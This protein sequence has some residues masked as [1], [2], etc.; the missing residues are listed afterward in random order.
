MKE[1]TKFG[2]SSEDTLGI[3]DLKTHFAGFKGSGIKTEKDNLLTKIRNKKTDRLSEVQAAIAE[4]QSALKSSGMDEAQAKKE[5]GT[6]WATDYEK[7]FR[8]LE[9]TQIQDHKKSLLLKIDQFVAQNLAACQAIFA[10][11]EEALNRNGLSE[12][13][14]LGIN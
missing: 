11:L 4:I 1:L 10:S 12:E 13:S 2:A 5:L 8:Y 6:T 9:S 7:H 14:V 3:K